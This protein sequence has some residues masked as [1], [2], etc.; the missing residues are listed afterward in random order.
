MKKFLLV[1]SVLSLVLTSCGRVTGND[2]ESFPLPQ[3][4]EIFLIDRYVNYAWGYQED[5][6]FV[7]T[8]GAVYAFD[9]GMA[10]GHSSSDE[11]LF[12]KFDIIRE[13]IEPIMTID[14][15][16]I[17]ELY[18]LGSQIDPESEFNS[19]GVAMDA[20]SYTVSFCNPD[21]G[22]ITVCTLDG[23]YEGTLSDDSAKKFA[24]LYDKKIKY[25]TPKFTAPL[26]YTDYDIRLNTVECNTE[27]SGMYFL[28]S[29]EQLRIFARQCGIAIDDMLGDYTDYEQ[30]RYVYFVELDAAPAN[31]VLCTDN[32]YM[33]SH[34]EGAGFCNVAAYPR[35][36]G[37]FFSD[38]IP[39][40]DGG[41]WQ[42]IK[43]GD[44]NS[45]PDFI[46]GEAYGFSETAM[47]EVWKDF[48]MHGFKGIYIPDPEK[49]EEFIQSCDSHN[50]VENGSIR[51]TLEENGVPD[52]SKYS[53]C[54]KLDRHNDNTKYEWQRTEIGDGYI[55]MG[56]SIS[57]NCG[58]TVGECT[59]AYVLIPKTYLSRDMYAVGC[60]NKNK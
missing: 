46:T 13:N 36:S 4:A 12:E 22:R 40:A 47:G 33:F 17:I 31:A 34:T 37:F 52:F 45:D 55:T 59:L 6:I 7:D 57:Q 50:L 44:L 43:E 42:R 18:S 24:E 53:L 3:T 15:D 35:S 48:N 14:S 9:F 20:G 58:N 19:E 21:T 27:M 49:Y 54:V 41:E 25:A 5:G 8:S 23:D 60:L 32:G 10:L 16:I 51:N 39:C 29:D 30:E 56:S 26:V 11:Q 28:S 38:S 1:I 2:S